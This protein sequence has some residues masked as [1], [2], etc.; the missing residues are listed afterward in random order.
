M[1]YV[2]G[3]TNMGVEKN[4]S[5]LEP[6]LRLIG[7]YMLNFGAIEMISYKYLDRLEKT[8]EE[9]LKNTSKLLGARISRIQELLRQSSSSKTQEMIETWEHVRELAKW[10]NR[11]AHNPVLPTWKPGSDSENSPPDVLGVS[12]MKQISKTNKVTDS[13]SLEALGLLNDHTVEVAEELNKLLSATS[14]A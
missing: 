2:K 8:E 9:F 4:P 6:W 7:S 3:I 1:S 5:Y 10:R 12:D 11:I 13:I 14:N